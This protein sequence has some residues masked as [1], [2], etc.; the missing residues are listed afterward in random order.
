MKRQYDDK[1]GFEFTRHFY[2]R[3]EISQSEHQ[4]KTIE[5]APKKLQ[6]SIDQS[7]RLSQRLT[8]S[9][10]FSLFERFKTAAERSDGKW[11]GAHLC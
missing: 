3:S 2:Y 7:D 5:T 11:L 6:S 1:V 8:Q 10:H 9:C 4:N